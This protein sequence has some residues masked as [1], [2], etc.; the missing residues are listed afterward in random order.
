MNFIK[1]AFL[2]DIRKAGKTLLL[3]SIL[4]VI[5]ILLLTCFSIRRGTQIAA[6]NI[7]QSERLLF[8]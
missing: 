1:R 7:R 8:Y 2:H 3:F 4:L 6:L 5:G